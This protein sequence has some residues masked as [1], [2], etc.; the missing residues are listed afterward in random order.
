MRPLFSGNHM[1]IRINS[2][3]IRDERFVRR[4]GMQVSAGEKGMG[5]LSSGQVVDLRLPVFFQP[6]HVADAVRVA[7]LEPVQTGIGQVGQQP[8]PPP[9]LVD[10]QMAAVMLARLKW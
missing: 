8:I 3:A 7:S 9:R 1:Y 4:Q 10:R 5:D 2:A 6:N